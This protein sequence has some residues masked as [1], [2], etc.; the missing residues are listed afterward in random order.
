MIKYL[1]GKRCDLD[2]F[3][4]T[5]KGLWFRDLYTMGM[6]SNE[7]IKDKE[8]CKSIKINSEDISTI[9]LAGRDFRMAPNTHS[10]I[11]I[12]PSRCHVLCL[13]DKGN[14]PELF[15]LFDADT[16][17]AINVVKM[18]EMIREANRHIGIKVVAGNVKYYKNNSTELL[19]CM[20]EEAVFRKPAEPYKK[21]SEYR[22]AI[23]WINGENS[24]LNTTEDGHINVFCTDAFKDDHITFTFQGPEFNQIVVGVTTFD[25]SEK[26]LTKS[27]GQS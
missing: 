7:N 27:R 1:Y 22:I 12:R 17:I 9:T 23:F 5:G 3:T 8:E 2:G 13:S 16:C 18:E 19:D 15:A 20:P 21:E 24:T 25:K 4:K 10:Y 6:L 14:D 11:S 26:D